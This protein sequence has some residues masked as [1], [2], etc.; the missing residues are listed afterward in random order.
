MQERLYWVVAEVLVLAAQLPAN[1]NLPPPAELRQRLTVVLDAMVGKARAARFGDEDIAEARY[2]LVAFI[3]EQILRSNWPGRA[4]W[5]AQPLQLQLYGEYTAG[6]NFFNRLRVLLQR[7]GDAAAVEVYYL[8]LLLGFRGVFGASAEP[9]ALSEFVRIAEQH[10]RRVVPN[11]SKLG[12]HAEP[13][14]QVKP[15]RASNAPFV[16]LLAACSLL[17]LLCVG[18]LYWRARSELRQALIV[19]SASTART[20]E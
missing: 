6:E 9:H 11:S 14:D 5:M 1:T 13:K 10:V 2:A 7:G 8:C 18:G 12:P 17:V 15:P 19:L 4:E 3:D 16:A 20:P